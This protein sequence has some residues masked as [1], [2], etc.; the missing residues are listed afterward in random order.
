MP[1]RNIKQKKSFTLLIIIILKIH[2]ALFN[3]TALAAKQ[4]S[5]KLNININK[6]KQKQRMYS[7]AK[8]KIKFVLKCIKISNKKLEFFVNILIA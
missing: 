2:C 3:G 5:S 7:T 8:N 6:C 1:F 4:A